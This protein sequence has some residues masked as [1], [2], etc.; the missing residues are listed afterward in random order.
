M[1][2]RKVTL[3]AREF[4]PTFICGKSKENSGENS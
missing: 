4:F 1:K 2:S 3:E